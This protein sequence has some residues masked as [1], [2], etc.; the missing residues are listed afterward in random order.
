MLKRLLILGAIHFLAVAVSASNPVEIRAK[1]GVDFSRY[2]TFAWKSHD[3]LV[4]DAALREGAPLDQK[5][6]RAGDKLIE[7]RGFK[8]VEKD[9][10]PDLIIHYVGMVDDFFQAD[11]ISK[12]IAPGVKW[13]GDPHSHDMRSYS[14]GTLVFEVIDAATGEMVWSGWATELAPTIPKLQDRAE[15]AT[16]RVFR[17]FPSR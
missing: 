5:I 14:S 10:S 15:K 8:R 4:K 16:R 12:E 3:Y 2:E 6:R 13:I 7:S 9:E 17:H 11:G 1:E